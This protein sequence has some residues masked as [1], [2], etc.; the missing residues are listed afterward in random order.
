MRYFVCHVTILML[1][2]KTVVGQIHIVVQCS[3]SVNSQAL[4]SNREIPPHS[5]NVLLQT[6]YFS[7]WIHHPHHPNDLFKPKPWEFPLISFF[8]TVN[9]WASLGSF[10]SQ[11]HPESTHFTSPRAIHCMSFFPV[12]SSSFFFFFPSTGHNDLFRHKLNP[13]FSSLKFFHG[14]YC[15]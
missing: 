7:Q 2:G 12:L 4:A 5:P 3:L 8:P 9:P 11:L 14:C 1:E 10:T 13:M 15:T 6:F